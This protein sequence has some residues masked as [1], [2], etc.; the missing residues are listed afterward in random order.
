MPKYTTISLPNALA[1][2]V[3]K[4][5]E[6]NGYSSIS[7]FVKDSCRRRLE[8]IGSTSSVDGGEEQEVVVA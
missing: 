2:E 6:I 7:E 3:K 8:E 4:V 1:H 5:L